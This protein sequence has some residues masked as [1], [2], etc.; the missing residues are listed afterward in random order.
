[1]AHLAADWFVDT[2]ARSA[3]PFRVAL[4]GGATP[5]GFYNLLALPLHRDR[6]DW[7]RLRFFWGDERLVPQDDPDSNYRMAR[8]ALLDHVPVRPEHIHPIPVDGTAEDAA[9]GYETTLKGLYG[10]TTLD[11]AKPLFDLMLLGLGADGHTASLIPGEPVL[12]EREK[13]VAGVDHGRKEARITLTY[14]AVE[15]SKTIAFLVT[16]RD[17]SAALQRVRSGDRALPAGRL[18]PQGEL[19]WFLDRAAAET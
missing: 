2:V 6:I 9:R 19:I 7:D 3:G 13:W 11:P 5:R 8:E 17:K 14:P 15:S 16:G 4:S 1:M 12:D 18:Q 10:A